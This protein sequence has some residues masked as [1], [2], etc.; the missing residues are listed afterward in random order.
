M[1]RI[2]LP[3][4]LLLLVGCGGANVVV[5]SDFPEPLVEPLPLHMGVYYSPEFLQYSHIEQKNEQ[6]AEHQ[7]TTGPSQVKLFDRLFNQFFVKTTPLRRLPSAEHPAPVTAVIMPQVEELQF[8]VPQ[9][10]RR[11]V[12]EVWIKYKISLLS[13]AGDLLME[14]PLAAYGKTP[15]AFMKSRDE[16]LEQAGIVALRDAGAHFTIS[17]T[18]LP[19]IQRWLDTQLGRPAQTAGEEVSV[20]AKIDGKAEEK[21]R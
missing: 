19:K 12:F 20:T 7:I 14:W 10:T 6:S 16:A 1:L 8:T 3:L 15:V 11:E 9:D 2:P 17:F 13:P 21:E 4:L 5:E 18:R